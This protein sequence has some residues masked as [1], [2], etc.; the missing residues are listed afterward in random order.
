[1]TIIF[2]RFSQVTEAGKQMTEV[3]RQMTEVRRQMTD[4]GEQKSDD[5]SE[6]L[7][8]GSCKQNRMF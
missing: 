1:M 4:V 8:R 3:G 6:I 7:E 2:G 5:P